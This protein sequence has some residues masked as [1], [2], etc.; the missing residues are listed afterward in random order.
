MSHFSFPVY[1]PTS[2]QIICANFRWRMIYVFG[3]TV[4]EIIRF[5]NLLTTQ[6]I[7]VIV[8][9]EAYFDVYHSNSGFMI[10]SHNLGMD[11][12][13][14]LFCFS[15]FFLFWKIKVGLSDHHAV[16]VSSPTTSECLNKSLWSLICISWHL[17]P[18]QRCVSQSPPISNTI[19]PSQFAEGNP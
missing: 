19:T 6:P 1:V 16:C 15:L 14:R 9:S 11:V 17:G 2:K 5:N 12:Y 3:Y 10:S 4:S 13:L 18:Y 8:R 7:I